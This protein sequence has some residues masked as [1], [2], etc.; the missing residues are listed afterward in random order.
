MF[1]QLK[2]ESQKLVRARRVWLSF[3]A[4]TA[5]VVLMLWGFYTYAEKKSGA[6]ATAGF[7]YTYE[8]KNYFNGLTFAL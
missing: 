7:K 1:T 5:F 6:G 2:L 4:L 3:I 8:S